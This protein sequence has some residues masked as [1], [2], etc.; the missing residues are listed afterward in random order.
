MITEVT[1]HGVM[2][3]EVQGMLPYGYKAYT[4]VVIHDV[5]IDQYN[6]Y[7]KQINRWIE[8]KRPVPNWLLNARHRHFVLSAAGKQTLVSY[9]QLYTLTLVT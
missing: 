8:A 2:M 6:D 5:H 4:G 9:R 3:D 7:T 1:K